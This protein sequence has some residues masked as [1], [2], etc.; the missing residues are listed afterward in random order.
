LLQVERTAIVKRIG[1]ITR[2]IAGLAEM[3]GADIV[4]E[5]LQGLLSKRSE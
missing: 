3:F 1:L 2:T 5:E 4:D